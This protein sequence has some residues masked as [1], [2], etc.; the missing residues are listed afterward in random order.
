MK[1]HNNLI[2]RFFF[3][4]MLTF[5]IGACEEEDSGELINDDLTGTI[6][7]Y[8]DP[9]TPSEVSETSNV[10][11]TPDGSTSIT[12]QNTLEVAVI[13]TGTDFSS[14][15]TINFTATTTYAVT[16]DFFDEGDDA[17][18]TVTFSNEGTI[19]IPAG[20]TRG[21]FF[22]AIADDV[23]ATGDR[24]INI[25][26]T[27]TS[28]GELGLTSSNPQ[29]SLTVTIIDDDC[30]ITI[31]DWVGVYTVDENFTAGTNAPSGLSDFFAESYQVEIALD[32]SDVT[33]TKGIITN[34]TGFDQYFNDGLVVTFLT[35]PGQVSFSEPAPNVA[36]FRNFVFETS[37]YSEGNFSIKCEGP[38]ATF[39]A[40]QFTLTKQAE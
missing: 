36:L 15:A 24:A 22:V 14:D 27:E 32:P 39:G 30:P 16:S 28:T 21:S 2:N 1:V 29:T 38:L 9:T 35:C 10:V 13:R 7:V 31:A 23:V 17:S 34:S 26:L 8:F 37:S 4:L 6:K 20:Q 19:T 12:T 25:T 5:V 3:L 11:S 18:G 40:Y 33:G